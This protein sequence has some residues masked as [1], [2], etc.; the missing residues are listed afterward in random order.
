MRRLLLIVALAGCDAQTADTAPV[1]DL[2]VGVDARV[3]GAPP[4][5]DMGLADAWMPDPDATGPGADAAAP[6]PDG[7]ALDPDEE[8]ALFSHQESDV[9]HLFPS[10]AR[11]NAARGHLPFGEAVSDRDLDYL[12][13]V[14]G[15]DADGARVFQ[16]REA[17]RG[18]VARAVLYV[19]VRWGLEVEAPEEAVL[20]RWSRDD[21]VDER[22]RR[23]NDAVESVQGNRNP[24]I[25]CPGLVGRVDDFAA[26][27]VLDVDLAS[28]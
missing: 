18:D 28:P 15:D 1:V 6:A 14:V 22:E 3:D 27:E 16:P 9:H 23:R 20:R 12:P 17:R 7:A 4:L 2:G 25:D 13:A 26:F 11:A 24:F 21:P 5:P 19:S 8:S 10:D